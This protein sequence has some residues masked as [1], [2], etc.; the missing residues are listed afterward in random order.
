MQFNGQIISYKIQKQ[1]ESK[2]L[3]N[4]AKEVIDTFKRL[5]FWITW[6]DCYKANGKRIYKVDKMKDRNNS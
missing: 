4:N 2:L 6:L 1:I 3:L 5:G